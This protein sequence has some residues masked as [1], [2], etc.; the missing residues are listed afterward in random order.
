MRSMWYTEHMA[1]YKKKKNKINP[2]NASINT[3]KAHI[4]DGSYSRIYLL[5]GEER[6]LINQFRDELLGALASPDDTM[7]VTRYNSDS[8]NIDSV[9]SDI[10]TVPFLAEHRVVLVEDSGLFGASD[11]SYLEMADRIPDTNV[12]IFCE[13][14][15]DK[16]R[17]TY[18]RTNSYEGATCLEFETPANDTLINWLGALLSEDGLKVK[19]S[20]P[21]RLLAAVGEDRNMYLLR[22]EAIKLHDYCLSKG[23]VTEED[24]ELICANSVEDKIFDMCRAISQK[25]RQT[26]IMLY[27]DL[28]RLGHNP[29]SVILA[30]TRQY[31]Q[32]IQVSQMLQ[33]NAPEGRIADQ[34]KIAS[35]AV[36]RLIGICRGY[37]HHELLLALDMCHEA[38]YSMT[39]GELTNRDVAENL[40]VNL[41]K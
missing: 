39:Q 40:I 4:R 2:T 34:L 20:V 31:N 26:A 7:N 12:L 14:K 32:L 15:V 18:K 29:A 35:W 11:P 33:E 10:I 37:T 38:F 21:D 6:F 36:A 22:N 9:M 24:V 13:T 19:L 41:I 23:V 5:F 28:L 1:T 8:F 30:I 25:N 16:N 27:N 3:I 17:T